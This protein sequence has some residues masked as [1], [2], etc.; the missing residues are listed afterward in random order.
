MRGA[1]G[2]GF[3]RRACCQTDKY[4]KVL[5]GRMWTDDR[6]R[7]SLEEDGG[8]G[9]VALPCDQR[10]MR[11]KSDKVYCSCHSL[12]DSIMRVTDC[13]SDVTTGGGYGDLAGFERPGRHE[14]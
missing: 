2:Q 11:W 14:G 9:R 5:E 1:R 8:E 7:A 10:A 12:S 3:D 6:R 4:G 13:A